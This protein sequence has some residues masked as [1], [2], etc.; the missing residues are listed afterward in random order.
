MPLGPH[1]LTIAVVI[2]LD[3][4]RSPPDEHRVAG[5]EQQPQ[6]RAKTLRPTIG[7]ADR[8]ERPV[9][10]A[11]QCAH[12]AA[13]GEEIRMVRYADFQ[14]YKRSKTISAQTR[15]QSLIAGHNPDKT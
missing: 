4:M 8:A 11:H 3:E 14:H 2:E 13:A 9:I 10:A 1:G 7:T 6:R 15:N 12:L 5:V